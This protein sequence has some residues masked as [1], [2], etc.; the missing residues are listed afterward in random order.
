MNKLMIAIG[1]LF[2]VY[3]LALYIKPGLLQFF[4]IDKHSL[5]EHDLKQQYKLATVVNRYNDNISSSRIELN[6]EQNDQIQ[7]FL[8]DNI[9]NLDWHTLI[10]RPKLVPLHQLYSDKVRIRVYREQITIAIINDSGATRIATRP[11][12]NEEEIENLSQLLERIVY[13]RDKE[14]KLENK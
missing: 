8:S 7:Q 14:N 10:F 13:E 1:S 9:V 2:L 11:F 3:N 4:V 5:N 6:E 12:K